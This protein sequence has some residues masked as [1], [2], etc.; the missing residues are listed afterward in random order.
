MTPT[1]IIAKSEFENTEM[2]QLDKSTFIL[3]QK[4]E[5]I[6]RQ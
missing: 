4:N 1:A 2:V 3:L 5:H 6:V